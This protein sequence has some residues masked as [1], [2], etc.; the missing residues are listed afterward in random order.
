[1]K[2]IFFFSVL[3]MILTAC[4]GGSSDSTPAPPS[5]VADFPASINGEMTIVSISSEIINNLSTLAQLDSIPVT[6][7]KVNNNL[8]ITA[9]G[10]PAEAFQAVG[11]LSKHPTGTTQGEICFYRNLDVIAATGTGEIKLTLTGEIEGEYI[12]KE[13]NVILSINA[14]NT[15]WDAIY[16]QAFGPAE[17]AAVFFDKVLLSQHIN[18][19]T[20]LLYVGSFAADIVNNFTTAVFNVPV[21]VNEARGI[22][23]M[24]IN[25]VLP[26]YTSYFTPKVV[27]DP[28]PPTGYTTVGLNDVNF[29][30]AFAPN[31]T[32]DQA[33]W[34]G[35]W[36][37][38]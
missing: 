18:D 3:G 5:P 14:N 13:C 34:Q 33:V 35:I 9:T 30:V 17:A 15:E 7:S 36:D 29:P 24:N 16:S 4:G 11:I 27:V 26:G 22:V 31:C 8:K 19:D 25:P 2:T 12:I 21:L 6:A 37:N 23:C 38:N 28:Q 20:A 10:V 1:M 32:F